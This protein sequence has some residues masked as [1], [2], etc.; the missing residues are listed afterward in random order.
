MAGEGSYP[1]SNHPALSNRWVVP[2]VGFEPTR[3]SEHL[4]LSQACLPVSPQGVSGWKVKYSTSV[5]YL[6]PLVH[7]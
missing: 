3:S 2:S 7:L 4:I 6:P 1:S 5:H